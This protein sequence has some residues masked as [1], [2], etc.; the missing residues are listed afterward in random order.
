MKINHRVAEIWASA[1]PKV[2]ESKVSISSLKIEISNFALVFSITHL[3]N[4]KNRHL[5]NKIGTRL[6]IKN[7]DFE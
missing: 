6:V 4:S 3:S 5:L 7:L 1:A 2:G